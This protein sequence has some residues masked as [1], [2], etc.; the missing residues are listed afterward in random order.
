VA[1]GSPNRGQLPQGQRTVFCGVWDSGVASDRVLGVTMDDFATR[2]AHELTPAG[3]LDVVNRTG[4]AG[5]FDVALDYFKPAALVMAVT[6][7]LRSSLRLA[8]FLSVDDALESQLG[9]KLVPTTTQVP[10][11]S[12]DEIQRPLHEP[13]QF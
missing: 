9:L 13:P 10:S 12:I 5:S 2:L 11:V 8:G 4:L 1:A 3:R 7:S 6:P